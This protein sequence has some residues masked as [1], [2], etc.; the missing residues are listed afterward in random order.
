MYVKKAE[1]TVAPL[2]LQLLN[3]VKIEDCDK[4]LEVGCGGS[5][6]LTH[7]LQRKKNS[8]EIHLTDFSEQM[9]A[10]TLHKLDKFVAHPHQNIYDIDQAPKPFEQKS[11]LFEQFNLYVSQANSTELTALGNDYFDCYIANLVIHSVPN[12]AKMYQEAHRVVKKGGRAI[13]STWGRIEHS[14]VF[15]IVFDNIKKVGV[16]IP[17]QMVLFHSGNR[18]QQIGYLETAGFSTV[19]GWYQ[20]V[21]VSGSKESDIDRI[22][23]EFHSLKKVFQLVK[24]ELQNDVFKS[25]KKDLMD[26]LFV[27]KLPLGMEFLVFVG[28]KL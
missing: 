24:P 4:I 21:A 28:E 19:M 6:L 18:E 3:M 13:F 10:Y 11:K 1:S 9:L 12:V 16:E 15:R 5:Y 22:F 7:I 17:A 14:P 27:Q 25:I 20:F 26:Y 23:E 8:A 2:L